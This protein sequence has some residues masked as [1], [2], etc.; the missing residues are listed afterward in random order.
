MLNNYPFKPLV[1]PTIT[2]SYLDQKAI[3]REY[4][5]NYT[6]R[7]AM[8]TIRAGSRE[9]IRP[10]VEKGGRTSPRY[11]LASWLPGEAVEQDTSL[12]QLGFSE[13]ARRER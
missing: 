7:S 6:Y 12:A 8:T 3:L 11:T 2:S 1:S 10:P 4:R 5:G 13:T 9:H